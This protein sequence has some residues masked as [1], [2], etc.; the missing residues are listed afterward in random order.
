MKTH[1]RLFSALMFSLII[2]FPTLTATAR[3]NSITASSVAP[4]LQTNCYKPLAITSEISGYGEGSTSLQASYIVGNELVY[5]LATF[6]RREFGFKMTG[7]RGAKN[8]GKYVETVSGFVT[9]QGDPTDYTQFRTQYEYFPQQNPISG[10]SLPADA[11]IWSGWSSL[12]GRLGTVHFSRA[13]DSKRVSGPYTSDQAYLEMTPG[14]TF[15]AGINT[16]IGYFSGQS[17]P[18]KAYIVNCLVDVTTLVNDIRS[19]DGSPVTFSVSV[20]AW[21]D[22]A[23]NAAQLAAQ[24]YNNRVLSGQG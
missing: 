9:N 4:N 6:Q 23:A 20:Q 13:Y 14:V 24:D 17:S 1:Y 7:K 16:S 10:K 18:T 2:I 21:R 19:G 12:G 11:P 3:Q 22:A 8:L 5:D 15:T